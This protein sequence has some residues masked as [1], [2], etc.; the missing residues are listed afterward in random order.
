MFRP[1]IGS[2]IFSST[3]FPRSVFAGVIDEAQPLSVGLAKIL[4][5]LLSIIGVVAIIGLVI[6]GLLY[7][8]AA[9]DMRQLALA[10]KATLAAITGIVIALGGYVLIRT[11]A[12]FVAG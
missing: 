12:T 9:G 8:F 10:K 6:A 5:F 4:D 11:I 3:L 2:I 7:F 1:I